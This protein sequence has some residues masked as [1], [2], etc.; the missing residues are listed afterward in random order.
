MNRILEVLREAGG[1]PVRVDCRMKADL[2]WF[3]E[4]LREYNSSNIF[5]EVDSC[6]IGGGGRMGRYCY[7]T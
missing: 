1:R 7:A 4:F 3:I 5:I 2:T 6:M